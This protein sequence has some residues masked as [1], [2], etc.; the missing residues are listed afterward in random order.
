M[1]EELDRQLDQ[2]TAAAAAMATQ[3][4]GMLTAALA[5]LEAAD[6]V[7][8]DVVAATD[9]QVDRAYE[10]LQH[11]V[12]ATVALHGPV[13]H[14]LRRLTGLIHVSLHL[15]R[16]GDYARNLAREVRRAAGEPADAELTQQLLEM[17]GL[18]GVVART[19]MDAFVRGDEELAREAG[20]ADDAVDQLNIGVFQRLVALGG[21]D[22]ERLSWATRM[23]AVGRNLERYADHG[24]DI[25]EQALFVATGRYVDLNATL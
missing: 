25:A 19:A 7:A 17:G 6:P 22:E 14:D 12:L 16:M 15:E 21:R 20:R 13:G 1:R 4:D 18:A 8:A 9:E 23:T 3:V 5:A 24:V 11:G 10:Q 2:L